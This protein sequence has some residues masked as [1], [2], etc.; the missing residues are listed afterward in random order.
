[1]IDMAVGQQIGHHGEMEF[2]QPHDELLG[3]VARI[4]DNG[5]AGGWIGHEITIFF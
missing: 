4:D 5:L 3:I 1:M 2:A